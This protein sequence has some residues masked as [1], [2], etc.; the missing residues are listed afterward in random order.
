MAYDMNGKIMGRGRLYAKHLPK[1]FKRYGY[2]KKYEAGDIWNPNDCMYVIFV[3]PDFQEGDLIIGNCTNDGAVVPSW[4]R[5]FKRISENEIQ[6][7]DWPKEI[8]KPV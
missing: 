7:I 4:K 5:K 2:K 8:Y 1:K 6:D 3:P